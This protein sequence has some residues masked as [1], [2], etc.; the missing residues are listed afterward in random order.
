M[1]EVKQ[2][3]FNIINRINVIG[4]YM[5]QDIH[6]FIAV[7]GGRVF[8]YES[9]AVERFSGTGIFLTDHRDS[10]YVLINGNLLYREVKV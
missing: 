3:F 10:T 7:E 8:T 9:I 6:E 2:Q 5:D 1:E 4:K